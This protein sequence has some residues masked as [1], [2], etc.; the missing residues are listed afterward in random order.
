MDD[1]EV[2]E[3]L[4][5]PQ[6]KDHADLLRP[7]IIQRLRQEERRDDSSSTRDAS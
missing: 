1:P 2:E 3:V 4:A 7:L 6:F 5:L